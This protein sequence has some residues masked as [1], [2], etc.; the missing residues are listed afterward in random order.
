[1]ASKLL[2]R[3][4]ISRTR[5]KNTSNEYFELS[6]VWL[7][8]E[9]TWKLLK[10]VMK[11]ISTQF[12]RQFIKLLQNF[13]FMSTIYLVWRNVFSLNFDRFVV[14]V[15]IVSVVKFPEIFVVN[16]CVNVLHVPRPRFDQQEF[17]TLEYWTPIDLRIRE[18]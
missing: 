16:W 14:V 15:E 7:C 3:I 4:D 9:K 1:M 13:F 18:R 5:N 6:S 12:Q 11:R 8:E 10:C 17:G 2:F